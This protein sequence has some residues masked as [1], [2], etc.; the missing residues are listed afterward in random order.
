[1]QP[2]RKRP[3]QRPALRR[4]DPRI[5]RGGDQP[6]ANSASSLRQSSS[7]QSSRRAIRRAVIARIRELLANGWRDRVGAG[8]VRCQADNPIVAGA[9][10]RLTMGR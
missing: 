5:Q 7:T 6:V 9:V 3:H 2:Q 10:S 8:Q 4:R 1:M